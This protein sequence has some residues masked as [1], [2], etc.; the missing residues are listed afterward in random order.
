MQ[1]T[2]IMKNK[3]DQ[4]HL[5]TNQVLIIFL[6]LIAFIFDI[7]W[8]VPGI[9][10]ILIFGSLFK[11]PG[12]A[13]VNQLLLYPLGLTKPKIVEDSPKPHLFAQII[14]AITLGLAAISLFFNLVV[15]GWLLLAIIVL[16]ASLNL[17]FGYCLGCSLYYLIYRKEIKM[18]D[19]KFSSGD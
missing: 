10:I 18:M 16:L 6:S 14:G 15:I 11:R 12:F 5:K 2:K 13:F 9:A 3:V 7:K 19:Y 1:T 4:S 8:V 17:F